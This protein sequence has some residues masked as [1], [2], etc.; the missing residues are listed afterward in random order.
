[1]FFQKNKMKKLMKEKID[2]YDKDSNL[3]VLTY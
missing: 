2:L 3:T 1:M